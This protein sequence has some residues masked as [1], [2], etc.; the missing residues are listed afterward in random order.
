[1]ADAGKI[2]TNAEVL[3]AIPTIQ[4]VTL[5]VARIIR[6]A[7][8]RVQKRIGQI[9]V[10][11][12]TDER[13]DLSR[14][15]QLIGRPVT[16]FTSLKYVASVA[17]DGTLSTAT[18]GRNKYYVNES[19]GGIIV[20][21]PYLETVAGTQYYPL[22]EDKFYRAG[23]LLATYTAGY[24]NFPEEIVDVIIIEIHRMFTI[25]QKSA[26]HISSSESDFGIT[27]YLRKRW[28]PE[29]ETV[30]TKYSR[31]MVW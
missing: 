21:E 25:A 16:V 12:Y 29:Q 13:H 18:V 20:L 22:S 24:A 5:D 31:P 27:N 26:W 1:M 7:E 3:A 6:A 9:K 10:A 2:V 23:R 4:E 15:I 14:F 30:L 19:I 28:L 8:G 11:T 17:E